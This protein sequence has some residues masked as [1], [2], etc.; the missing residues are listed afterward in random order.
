[1]RKDKQKIL[2]KFLKDL[3]KFYK[4]WL[5]YDW[6]Y[7]THFLNWFCE[8][9]KDYFFNKAIKKFEWKYRIYN[10]YEFNEKRIP[11]LVMNIYDEEV[12]K[13]WY[14]GISSK[15]SIFCDDRTKNLLKK[16]LFDPFLWD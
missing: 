13:Y 6:G 16:Y 4:I 7:T 3:E 2:D 14:S 12:S 8:E 11:C 1:M 5:E 9:E 15:I 10:L